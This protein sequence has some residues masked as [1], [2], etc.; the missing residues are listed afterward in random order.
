MAVKAF[1]NKNPDAFYYTKNQK[2]GENDYETETRRI[3]KQ[4]N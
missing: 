1:G 2:K 3:G 4:Q